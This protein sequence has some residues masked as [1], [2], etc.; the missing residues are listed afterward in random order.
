[1][2]LE[3][4]D[5][6]DDAGA[7]PVTDAGTAAP[8]VV[9]RP[10]AGRAD[11][12]SIQT[13]YEP[14]VRDTAITFE[15]VVPTVDEVLARMNAHL[16]KPWLIAEIDGEPAGYAYASQHAARSAYRWSADV[17]VY[18]RADRRGR[19]LGRLLYDRLISEV[20]A[21]GYVTLFAGIT[22]PNQASVG[23][24]TAVGFRLAGV[25][26]NT[27]HKFGRWHDVAWYVLPPVGG[28]PANPAEPREWTPSPV[29]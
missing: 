29:G 15:E 1:M 3:Q 21:L 10:A 5:Q 19:G 17:S 8:S 7:R 25:H 14:W 24:H 6:V 27:G 4:V 26:P 12:A 28:P 16:R 20:R 11:A 9:V 2:E 23:L 18:L 22:Q 13:I